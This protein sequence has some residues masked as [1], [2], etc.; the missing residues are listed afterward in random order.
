MSTK[1]LQRVCLAGW[2][3]LFLLGACQAQTFEAQ[4][5]GTV[6]D[7]S[8]AVIPN[9]RLNAKNIATGRD[10][11]ATSNGSGIYRFP[12]LPPAQ[13]TLTTSLP[14]FKR[15][16]QGPITLAVAQVLEISITLQPGDAAERVTV[17]AAP[18]P[19]ETESATLGK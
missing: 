16:E 13:Y 6:R 9:A 2:A 17:S 3:G 5:T 8:G 14:G 19:L 11:S 1:I 18:P 7:A 10:F 15:F 12:S 4:I